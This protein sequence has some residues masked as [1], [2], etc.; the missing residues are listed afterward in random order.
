MLSQVTKLVYSLSYQ[1][2]RRQAQF[3]KISHILGRDHD[4]FKLFN[5][6][7]MNVKSLSN[8]AMCMIRFINITLIESQPKMEVRRLPYSQSALQNEAT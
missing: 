6:L 4:F 5:A 1:S 7:E 3:I 8:R 2:S